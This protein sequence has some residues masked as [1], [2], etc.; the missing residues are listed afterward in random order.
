MVCVEN[1]EQFWEN[2]EDIIRKLTTVVPDNCWTDDP[3][4]ALPP[5]AVKDDPPTGSIGSDDT[6]GLYIRA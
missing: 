4:P 2:I 6:C 5:W 3:T 1:R